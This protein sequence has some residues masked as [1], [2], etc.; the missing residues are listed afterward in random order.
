VGVWL[1]K[2]VM[3]FYGFMLDMFVCLCY[4][5]QEGVTHVYGCS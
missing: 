5:T 3:T 1:L 4:A 2:R